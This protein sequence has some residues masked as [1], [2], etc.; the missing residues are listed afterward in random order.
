MTK[1]KCTGKPGSRS[2]ILVAATLLCV[3]L[4]SSHSSAQEAQIGPDSYAITLHGI[5]LHPVSSRAARITLAQ[6]GDAAMEVCGASSSSLT[7]VQ[8]SVRNSTCWHDSVAAAIAGIGDK[9]LADAYAQ[10]AAPHA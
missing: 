10:E 4:C 6:I 3:G 1:I 8:R 7:E 2:A 5:D 9:Q